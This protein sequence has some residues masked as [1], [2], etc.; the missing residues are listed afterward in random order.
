[1][2]LI[3][4][5]SKIRGAASSEAQAL[6]LIS[7]YDTLR[8]LRAEGNSEAADAVCAIYFIGGGRIPRKNDISYAVRRFAIAKSIDERTVWRRLETAK[9]LYHALVGG[10]EK[11]L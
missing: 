11:C 1:M 5:A 9:R 10:Q 8:V 2:S 6:R 3:D 4:A 7:V